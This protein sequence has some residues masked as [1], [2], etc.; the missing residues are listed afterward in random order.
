MDRPENG[1]APRGG[2]NGAAGNAKCNYENYIPSPESQEK[3][4]GVPISIAT[5]AQFLLTAFDP[6]ETICV[7]ASATKEGEKWRPSTAGNLYLVSDFLKLLEK[8]GEDVFDGEPGAWIRINPIKPGDKSGTDTSVA[9]HRHVLVEFDQIPKADQYR[10]MKQSGLPITAIIDSGGKSLHFWIK[11]DARDAAEFKER[12]NLIYQYLST[13]APDPANKNP[14]RYSRLPGVR[15]NGLMQQLVELNELN[16]LGAEA[17]ETW[18]RTYAGDSPSDQAG[19]P[20]ASDGIALT[21]E[22]KNF[23]AAYVAK[24]PPAISHSHGHDRTFEVACKLYWGFALSIDQARPFLYDY[25]Q[26]CEPPWNAKDLERKLGEAAK[27]TNHRYPRGHLLERSKPETLLPGVGYSESRFALAVVELLPKESL[28]LNDDTVVEIIDGIDP[29]DSIDKQYEGL[30]FKP[31]NP[32]RFKTWVERHVCTGIRV[33]VKDKSGV[34]VLNTDGKPETVFMEKTMSTGQSA[35]LLEAPNFKEGLCRIDRILDVPIPIRVKD[36][37]Y[38]YPKPGYNPDL[39]VYCNPNAPEV[40]SIGVEEAKKVIEEVYGEFCFRDAQSKTH[41]IARLLTPYLRGV[42]GFRERIPFWYFDG[43]RPGAGK[44]YCNGVTQLVYQGE[45]FEDMPLGN[46]P[47]ETSKRI[48][49]AL[50]AGRR[51]MHFANNQGHLDDEYFIAAVTNKKICGRRLGSNDGSADLELHNE[52]DYS[53]SANTGLTVRED[54][55]R[56]CRKISLAYFEEHENSRVYQKPDLHGWILANRSRILSA[57]HTLFES[58]A[59]ANTNKKFTFTSFHKWG[60]VLGNV[61][62]FHGL[63]N[64]CLEHEIGLLGGDLKLRAITALYELA[65]EEDQQSDG[66]GWWT[67]VQIFDLIVRHQEDDDRLA[68]FGDLVSEQQRI[69]SRTKT[70]ITLKEFSGRVLGG[71]Q[72]VVDTSSV[73]S[74]RHRMRFSRV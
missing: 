59:S 62:D 47:A 13:W 34:G 49:S 74:G 57:I 51:M 4:D 9:V 46:N 11:V 6:D 65:Y 3:S 50:S 10:I 72:M 73:N 56:R 14:S 16:D 33:K 53:I 43:N 1:T 12:S 48:V 18:Q 19:P 23:I 68:F 21:P 55:E 22:L 58:W 66:D 42:I 67:K 24:I 28:F 7:T 36:G 8:E 31:M 39:G 54:I 5:P 64:P 41:A 60:L 61:M 26:R 17:F 70:G 69:K 45:V 35:A 25:N 38:I 44:D 20:P 40:K 15:R 30:R 63:D 52:I 2:T 27:A 32:T 37:R 29:Y 71:I